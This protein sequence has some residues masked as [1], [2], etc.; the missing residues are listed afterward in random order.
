MQ[1]IYKI[2]KYHE[3]C[4]SSFI[5]IHL[6]VFSVH[7]KWNSMCSNR[8]NFLGSKTNIF[9]AVT[10]FGLSIPFRYFE[11]KE[12]LQVYSAFV[13]TFSLSALFTRAFCFKVR[14]FLDLFQLLTLV[15]IKINNID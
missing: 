3:S 10:K 4:V 1:I 12:N 8:C 11:S 2:Y 5:V 6:L 9:L 15:S 13:W 14:T 7:I